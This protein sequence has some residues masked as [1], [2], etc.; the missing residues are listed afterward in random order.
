MSWYVGKYK[1][2]RPQFKFICQI[3]CWRTYSMMYYAH[4]IEFLIIDASILLPF[5]NRLVWTFAL[6][7]AWMPMTLC[8]AGTCHILFHWKGKKP[9][10]TPVQE[11][12]GTHQMIKKWDVVDVEAI[13]K[14]L[15]MLSIKIGTLAACYS[16]ANYDKQ[17]SDARG[18]CDCT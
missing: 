9:Q 15:F 2:G 10:S 5:S 6:R 11:S 3:S 13:K 7:T 8:H 17:R 14:L 16:Q 18:K 1:R 12:R 4:F